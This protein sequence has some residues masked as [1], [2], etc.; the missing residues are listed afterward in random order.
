MFKI[1]LL[2]AFIK[3]TLLLLFWEY[4]KFYTWVFYNNFDK[5]IIEIFPFIINKQK[6]ICQIWC[7]FKLTNIYNI[8][9][10]LDKN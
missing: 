7:I 1:E 9:E 6:F 2:N 8:Y 3:L 10:I 5:E 4:I